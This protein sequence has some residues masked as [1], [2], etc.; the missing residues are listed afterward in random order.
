MQQMPLATGLMQS[1]YSLLDRTRIIMKTSPVFA[2]ALLVCAGCAKTENASPG[3]SGQATVEVDEA[4]I[5]KDLADCFVQ[6]KKL[7]KPEEVERMRSGTEDDMNRYHFGLG[8]WIRNNWG[9]WGGSPLAKW[10]NARGIKHPD[11]MSGIILD[12]FWRHLNDKPIK[13]EEQVK[14]YQDYWKEPGKVQPT[15]PGDK[16]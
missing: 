15:D 3:P 6:L 8:M 5:P 14:R 7:L 9:L 4:Y 16:K 1:V 13:L 11:D 12:S 10:F 2:V